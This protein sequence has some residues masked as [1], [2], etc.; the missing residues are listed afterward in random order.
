MRGERDQ[1][2]RLRQLVLRRNVRKKALPS[3]AFCPVVAVFGARSGA[4]CS[5]VALGLQN[6]LRRRGWHAVLVSGPSAEMPS[7]SLSIPGPASDD[8]PGKITGDRNVG[9]QASEPQRSDAGSLVASFAK[10]EI[11]IFDVGTAS[12]ADIEPRVRHG[13]I[14]L[15]AP[16]DAPGLMRAYAWL[17]TAVKVGALERT[18]L[19]FNFVTEEM[20]L[21]EAAAR[22]QAAAGRFLAVEVPVWAGLPLVPEGLLPQAL[23]GVEPALTSVER[24]PGEESAASSPQP[25]GSLDLLGWTQG[26]NGVADRLLEDWAVWG[27]NDAV[28]DGMGVPAPFPPPRAGAA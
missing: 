12:P 27:A 17:K 10:L 20:P 23:P 1:A 7:P 4:G 3:E 6:L 2:F 28:E 24:R 14:L 19:L 21:E 9:V 15:V 25:A 11:R 22:V 26:L 13:R 5:S 18:A 16:A 8:M